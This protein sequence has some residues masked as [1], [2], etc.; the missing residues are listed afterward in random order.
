MNLVSL[1]PS[2]TQGSQSMSPNEGEETK[3]QGSEVT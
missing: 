3:A 1:I 2:S